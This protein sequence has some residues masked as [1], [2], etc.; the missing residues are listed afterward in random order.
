MPTAAEIGDTNPRSYATRP[1]KGTDKY[2]TSGASTVA[3]GTF[4]RRRVTASALAP[5]CWS[6]ASEMISGVSNDWW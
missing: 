6:V 2:T 3:S 5:S 1:R 4:P